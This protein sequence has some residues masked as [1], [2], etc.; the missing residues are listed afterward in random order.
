[1]VQGRRTGGVSP[2]SERR[3]RLRS[4]KPRPNQQPL[5]R[6]LCGLARGKSLPQS[7][8]R[9]M[10]LA[11][12]LCPPDLLLD[13]SSP[14]SRVLLLPFC[15]TL[16]HFHHASYLPNTHRTS[17]ASVTSINFWSSSFG[18]GSTVWSN[19]SFPRSTF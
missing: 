13:S 18:M 8:I 12:A 3:T 19:R 14:A 1:L 17:N 2:L 10:N 16:Y 9:E 6:C 5:G 7:Q 11:A 15:I 4:W